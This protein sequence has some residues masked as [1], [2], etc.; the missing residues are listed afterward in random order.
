MKVSWAG[1]PASVP[2]DRRALSAALRG[3]VFKIKSA[4]LGPAA[5]RASGLYGVMIDTGL[6]DAVVSLVAL[7]DGSVSLYVTDGSGCIGCGA[8][9]DV[10]LAVTELLRAADLALPQ[11]VAA[12]DQKSPPANSL[13]C[14]LLTIRGVHSLQ[15][16]LEAANRNDSPLG[17]LYFAGLHLLQTVERVGAGHSLQTEIDIAL[18]GRTAAHKPTHGIEPCLSVGNAVRRLRT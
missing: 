5:L 11:A 3:Q 8:H 7:S 18:R 16:T 2:V 4:D 13:R 9:P 17:A 15:A 12:P 1:Q 14:F 10:R 6:E